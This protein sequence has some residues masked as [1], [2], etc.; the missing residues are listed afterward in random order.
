MIADMNIILKKWI[1]SGKIPLYEHKHRK[2][3][4]ELTPA[5][6]TSASLHLNPGLIS[7]Y[8]TSYVC[9]TTARLTTYSYRVFKYRAFTSLSDFQNSAP[10]TSD[11]I[12][13]MHKS[14]AFYK[15]LSRSY[16]RQ[17]VSAM[18]TTLLY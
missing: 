7:D 4:N 3:H 16:F 18:L 17:R 2:I 14:F 15:P 9:F 11:L 5:S 8:R 1:H 13:L 12:K 6:S 10:A